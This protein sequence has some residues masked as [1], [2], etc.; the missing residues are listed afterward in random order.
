[1]KWNRGN[2][3]LIGVGKYVNKIIHIT[4]I[5]VDWIFFLIY[6]KMNGFGWGSSRYYNEDEFA[7]VYSIIRYFNEEL[8]YQEVWR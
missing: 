2:D 5:K 8:F 3:D 7:D 4:E 6:N 1:M